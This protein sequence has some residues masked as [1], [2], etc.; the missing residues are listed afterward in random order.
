[1]TQASNQP[2]LTPEELAAIEANNKL[3]AVFSTYI[4]QLQEAN[5]DKELPSSLLYSAFVLGASAVA[6]ANESTCTRVAKDI[7][8]MRRIYQH[9]ATTQ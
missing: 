9:M 3:L 6:R 5:P 1:M 2:P 8:N 7:N 4:E